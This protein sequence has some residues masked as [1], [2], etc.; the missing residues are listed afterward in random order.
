MNE[1][2]KIFMKRDGM[3]KREAVQRFKG[4]REEVADIINEG[5]S[6][7]EVEDVLLCERL[8]MDYVYYFI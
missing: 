6:Y 2:I 5:G 8:E 3:T 4:V 1:V 7:D